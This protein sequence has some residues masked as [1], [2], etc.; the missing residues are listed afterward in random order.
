MSKPT[1]DSTLR[2]WREGEGEGGTHEEQEGALIY[3]N[4]L[5]LPL[6]FCNSQ[7]CAN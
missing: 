2:D 3:L 5:N 7:I 6:S 1:A 4:P